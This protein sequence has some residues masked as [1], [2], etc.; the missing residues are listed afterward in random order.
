M[1]KKRAEYGQKYYD[2]FA[3]KQKTRPVL[4]RGSEG[5]DVVELQ[6]ILKK[7]GF[8]CGDIDGSFGPRVEKAVKDLQEERGLTPD[9][10][11]GPKTWA[12]IDGFVAYE[13]VVNVDVLNVRSKPSTSGSVKK[14]IRRNSK[15]VI[16]YEKNGW[17]KL[18]NGEGWIALQYVKKI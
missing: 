6:K 12:A 18:S 10:S 4:K 7:L 8:D 13:V 14:Q 9:G 17:G 2:Q 3:T 1:Q 16:V 15:H 5:N 11:C